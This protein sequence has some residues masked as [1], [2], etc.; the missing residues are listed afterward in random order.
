MKPLFILLV[1]VMLSAESFSQTVNDCKKFGSDVLAKSLIPGKDPAE[2]VKDEKLA[3]NFINLYDVKKLLLPE[4]KL[5]LKESRK[6]FLA[7]NCSGKS[8]KPL[9][10]C[11][12]Y[13]FSNFIFI[14][15][16]TTGMKNHGWKPATILLGKQ[17]IWDYMQEV[18]KLGGVSSLSLLTS[19]AN[20]SEL[21]EAKL[22]T[23]INIKTVTDLIA[24]MEK[25]S[26]GYAKAIEAEK[27]M[28]KKC[29]IDKKFA[30]MEDDFL[31][32]FNP[33]FSALLAQ[34]KKP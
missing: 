18:S 29:D 28:K 14:Q 12:S 16:L 6:E 15:G 10:F 34:W 17:K 5:T 22:I 4:V 31:A 23:G 7:N 1:S 20:L 3:L 19:A 9:P 25:E 21:I 2:L 13:G 30:N 32:K 27:D 11:E 24:D 8:K 33:K 26:E